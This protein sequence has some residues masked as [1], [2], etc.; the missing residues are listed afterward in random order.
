MRFWHCSSGS[1]AP[2][3][4]GGQAVM[5]ERKSPLR[6][7]LCSFQYCTMLDRMYLVG[8]LKFAFKLGSKE[9]YIR[10]QCRTFLLHSSKILATTFCA[11]CYGRLVLK[12]QLLLSNN[13]F[14][15]HPEIGKIRTLGRNDGRGIHCEALGSALR[16]V[17]VVQK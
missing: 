16:F 13:F 8:L 14:F 7:A 1:N 12:H 4:F 6:G 9:G 5:S 2:L 17:V 10:R 3:A 11:L 15:R